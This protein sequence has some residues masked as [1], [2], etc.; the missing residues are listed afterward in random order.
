MKCDICCLDIDVEPSG[1]DKGHNARPVSLGRCC[2]RCNEM[3]VIP[4]RIKL[5][6]RKKEDQNAKNE[7]TRGDI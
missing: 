2:S 4:A 5:L 6:L 7:T 1:W 3:S